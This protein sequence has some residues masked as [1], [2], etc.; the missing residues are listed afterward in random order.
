MLNVIDLIASLFGPDFAIQTIFMETVINRVFF[1][2]S[3]ARKF[4]KLACPKRRILD[5]L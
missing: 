5:S 1:L 2:F 3:K 4:N